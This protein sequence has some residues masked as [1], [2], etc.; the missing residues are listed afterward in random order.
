MLIISFLLFRWMGIINYEL[1]SIIS[2]IYFHYVVYVMWKLSSGCATGICKVGSE[3]EIASWP[4]W[5]I[6]LECAK[7]TWMTAR[8]TVPKTATHRAQWEL[9]TKIWIIQIYWFTMYFF[10]FIL[11]QPIDANLFNKTLTIFMCCAFISAQYVMS[12]V[13]CVWWCVAGT[14]FNILEK[15]S[16]Q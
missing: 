13:L 14:R 10:V 6:L 5:L 4:T 16:T 2:L 9:S 15:I 1:I 11:I 12:D 7:R 3:T 8:T